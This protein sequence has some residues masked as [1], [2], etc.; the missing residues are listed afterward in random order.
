MNRFILQFAIIFSLYLALSPLMSVQASSDLD[1]ITIRVIGLDEVPASSMQI[2]NL[3]EPDLGEMND[4]NE[5]IANSPDINT[6]ID[7]IADGPGRD[8]PESDM[9][10]VGVGNGN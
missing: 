9:P 3:P 6:G 4:I 8:S 10:E 1:D 5:A 2:I 7:A